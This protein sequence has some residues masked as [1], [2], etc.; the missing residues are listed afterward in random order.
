MRP[1]LLYLTVLA[2]L[3][4]SLSGAGSQEPTP[5][6]ASDL[7]DTYFERLNGLDET[8]ASIEAFIALYEESGQHIAGPR[9]DQLGTVTF[10]GHRN[11]R[12]MARDIAERFSEIAFRVETVTA[13]ERTTR[14]FHVAEGP[15]GGYAVAVE[16]VAAVTR[17]SDGVRLFHPG[18]A[19]FQI[20]EGKMR[21]VRLYMASGEQ[22]EV[23]P[24]N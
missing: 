4:G 7:V 11:L 12:K 24:L 23:E 2:L 9:A 14:L 17:K 18:A 3:A 6:E 16:Y 20:R 10:D 21:R 13:S 5:P 1:N 15:W 22:A 8:E 19:F